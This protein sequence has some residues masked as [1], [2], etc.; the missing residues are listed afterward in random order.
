M[1]DNLFAE[2]SVCAGRLSEFVTLPLESV[3]NIPPKPFDFAECFRV[4]AFV[5]VDTKH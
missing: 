3:L 4:A 1:P 5:R 2:L